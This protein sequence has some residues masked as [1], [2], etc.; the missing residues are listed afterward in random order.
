MLL[1]NSFLSDTSLTFILSIRMSDLDVI[2]YIS[3]GVRRM[4]LTTRM[5]V[6]WK[7]NSGDISPI[8]SSEKVIY[9][10]KGGVEVLSADILWRGTRTPSTK[11]TL[12]PRYSFSTTHPQSIGLSHPLFR[13]ITEH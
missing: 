7:L 11:R 12:V 2:I 4:D 8:A 5:A 3:N 9:K 13:L 1:P 10:I 6:T